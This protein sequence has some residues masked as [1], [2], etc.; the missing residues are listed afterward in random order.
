MTTPC[1]RL[2]ELGPGEVDVL[3]AVFDGLSPTSR[4]RR[5]HGP[6][7]VLTSLAKERLSAVDGRRH[8]AFAAFAGNQAVGIARLV[9]IGDREAELAV[10]VVDAWHNRGVGTRLV[11]AVVARGRVVGYREFAADVLAENRAVQ[12]LFAKV[13]RDIQVIADG[14]ELR[15]IARVDDQTRAA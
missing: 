8:I 3:Q 1:V 5:F 4:H 6:M 12:A 11:E 7:P 13:F 9:G 15:L 10:E 2:R 14:W